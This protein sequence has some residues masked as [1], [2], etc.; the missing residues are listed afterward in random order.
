MDYSSA[1]A[2]IYA[3]MSGMLKNTFVGK[4]S[5]RLFNAKSLSEL[6]E[7]IFKS[8]VPQIPEILLAN[9]IETEAV[10]LFVRQYTKLLQNYSKPDSFLIELL[11]RFDVENLKVISAALSVGE[12]TAPRVIRLGEYSSL[13]YDAWPDI[14]KITAGSRFS[15]YDK[16]PAEDERFLLDFKLDLEEIRFLWKSVNKVS[17]SSRKILV[18][19]YQKFFSMQNMLWA[20]RLKVY[21]KMSQ[22]DILKKLFY[23]GEEPSADD[24]ICKFACEILPKSI[25]NFEDWENWRFANLL[26]PHEDGSV[27]NV[28]PM[29]IEQRI[30]FG[31]TKR[32]EKLFHENSMTYASLVMFYILKLQEL[33]CIRAATEGLR[34]NVGK[35]EAMYVAGV[36]AEE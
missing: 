22:Q 7:L 23:V 36:S 18:D 19:F 31:E 34:L 14:K 32:V 35:E 21:Y 1:S 12:Q 15:W 27:W 9:K 24:P 11:G 3:K 2:Y 20:L 29:W 17:D 28:D 30:R 33:D 25:D 26:N 5:V 10:K 16:I 6:W 8:P 4:N 13:D